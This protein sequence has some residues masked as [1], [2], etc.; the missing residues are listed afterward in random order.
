MMCRTQP[1][2]EAPFPLG[3]KQQNVRLSAL[4]PG[5]MPINGHTQQGHFLEPSQLGFSY[6]GTCSQAD[7][8]Q[9]QG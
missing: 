8:D 4:V 3:E 5:I 9:E 1:R 6:L 2:P 7:T